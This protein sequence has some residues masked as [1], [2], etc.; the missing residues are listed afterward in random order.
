VLLLDVNVV[1]AA[2]RVDHAQHA[3][4]RPWFDDLL[5]GTERF[6][7]PTVVWGSFVR[8]ATSRR[9]FPRPTPLRETFEFVEAVCAQ[10]HHVLLS[11][12]PKHLE[13]LRH[14]C[15]EADASGDLIPD[16]VLAAIALEHGCV[17]ASMDRDFARFPS[18]DFVVPGA[19]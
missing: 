10:E 1:V 18:I 11:P 9:V 5:D 14:I 8:L 16:A 6:S 7:V 17:V 4:T 2:H 13:L 15:E 3:I 19:R 12:G